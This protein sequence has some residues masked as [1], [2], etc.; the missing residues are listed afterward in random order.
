MNILALSCIHN[1]VESIL[2]YSDKILDINFDLILCPG[3]FLDAPIKKMSSIELGRLIIASLK[4][5]EK[6]LLVVPGCWDKDLIEIFE[7]DG[8]S[9]HGKGIK[10]KD[11]GFYGFGGAKTPFSLPYEPS[12]EE[13]EQGLTQ[14]YRDVVDAKY[15][16]QLTHA[17]PANTK[18][19]MIAT[20]AH[21]G[22]L[23]VR[24]LIENLQPN[25]A[26]CAHIHESRGFD[27]IGE[28]VVVNPGRFPEGYCSLISIVGGK[29][30][31]QLINLT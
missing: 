11:V 30:D 17:P 1:D 4:V 2:N 29:V 31:V 9:V 24:K 19:D 25:V 6:P 14:A 22:S 5:F 7:K 20:G 16:V 8:I 28:S 27:K 26:V 23:S 10:I 18:L 21:V 15:K 3:D 12:E 13:I